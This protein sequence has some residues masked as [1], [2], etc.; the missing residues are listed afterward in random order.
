[1][2]P[3]KTASLE[4]C[5]QPSCLQRDEEVGR[6]FIAELVVRLIS[7]QDLSDLVPSDRPIAGAMPP[8]R[9]RRDARPRAARHRQ[10][11]EALRRG[12]GMVEKEAGAG[13]DEQ[14]VANTALGR[15]SHPSSRT[16]SGPD[17]ISLVQPSARCLALRKA[18]D[19]AR[20]AR[21]EPP[22]QRAVGPFIA[23]QEIGVRTSP[24]VARRERPG[25]GRG[26]R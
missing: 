15:R 19:P 1:M 17:S 10:G 7:G 21:P 23:S 3:G 9:A 2:G 6:E 25:T 12:G 16:R 4:S 18:L 14:N 26:T 11:S 24:P 8:L 5:T 20:F 13:Q 22:G